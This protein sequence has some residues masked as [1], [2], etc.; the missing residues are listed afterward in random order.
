MCRPILANPEFVNY[1][2]NS[3]YA[4]SYCKEVKSIGVQQCNINADKIGHFVIPLAPIRE[5]E[6][7]VEEISNITPLLVQYGKLQSSLDILNDEI[8]SNLKKSLLDAA[9]K[10]RLV[11]QDPNNELASALLDRIRNEKQKLLKE[12]KLKKKDIVDSVIFKG[13]DNK[14]YEQIGNTT[15]CIDDDLPFE[16]PD[17]WR[18]EY[19]GNLVSNSTGLA[20]SKESLND[21][22]GNGKMITV[23]R[24]GNIEDGGWMRKP[25]DVKIAEKYV[26]SSLHLRAGTFI[27]PAVTSL[28][29]IGKTALIEEDLN[30]VVAGGF[31]LML[32]PHY[33][34]K[35][36]LKFMHLFFQS[37]YY[38]QYCTSITNKSGQAFYNLSRTKL[39]MCRVPIPPLQEIL[40]IVAKTSALLEAIK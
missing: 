22:D 6:R 3:P 33:R 16:I 10:G 28:E 2:L 9:I 29:R 24:G 17:S 14:Y 25:D 39:M 35:N 8:Q 38:K 20:Y 34:E 5:Q 15:A 4:R 32:Q 21:I 30:D 40:R 11:P 37:G 12:G 26:P 1:I 7:I 27:S 18:W 13:D 31:V 19:L 23:L 36:L